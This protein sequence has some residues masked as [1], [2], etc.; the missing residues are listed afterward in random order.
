[1]QTVSKSQLWT[2][3]I[4]SGLAAL[5]LLMDGVGKVVKAGPV[6]EGS[7]QLGYPESTV[8][9]IGVLVLIGTALYVF[10]RTSVLGA[11]YLTGF[12]GGAIAT[13]VRVGS[14]LFTH[15][16]FPVYLALM[17]WAGLALRSP[18]LR[19]VLFSAE[20]LPGVAEEAHRGIPAR[21]AVAR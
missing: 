14:P 12:L 2:G 20:P 1:M 8:V 15:T 11:I 3:R 19:A 6:V 13:H 18:R 7:G 17:L 9:P 4:L 10:R 16:L 5:F 21:E